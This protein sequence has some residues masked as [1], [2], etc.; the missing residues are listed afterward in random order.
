[1]PTVSFGCFVP[2]A[3]EVQR[4]QME[5]FPRYLAGRLGLEILPF[6]STEMP[7]IVFQQPDNFRG[8]QPFRGLDKPTQHIPKRYNPWG[9]LCQIEP[10]YWGE[11]DDLNEEIMTK[12]GGI[13]C[14][15]M[16]DLTEYTTML[17]NQLLERRANR[18]E[19]SIWQSLVF[20]RYTA[21]NSSGQVI[22]EGE[23]NIQNTSVPVPWTN[24][25]SS[26]PLR[27]FRQIQLLGRG[28][29]TRFDS[30]ARAYMNR[31]TANALMS[32]VNVQDVGR[33]GLSACCTFMS[34]A[35][36]NEQFMAQG[37]PQIQIY[38][39]GYL[40]DSGG[41]NVYIP[42]GYVVIVGCRPGN[43]PVGHYWLTR[44][45]VGCSV[46][47]GFWQKLM[48]SCDREI[49]RKITIADGHN[50]GPALEYARSVVVMRVF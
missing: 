38:D 8:L 6:K 1:M 49:P 29:S 12:W 26:F 37:L 50:G 36:I 5:L 30:C 27:D 19:Y 39:E 3:A 45:A 42:D 46:T 18:I 10:G 16:L 48:D 22:H 33:V 14:N 41:F 17:Q 20:G 31:V 13:A 44:N 21:L 24:F 9:T 35:Q 34:P 28:T 32:N 23:F 7:N 4:L 11:H 25:A 2:T 43:V 15:T 47:S 40:D